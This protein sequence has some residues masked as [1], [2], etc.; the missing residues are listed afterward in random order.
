[1][2]INTV[3]TELD[4]LT[5]TAPN[6][7]AVRTTAVLRQIPFEQALVEQ[8]RD[9][10][11]A[12]DEAIERSAQEAAMAIGNAEDVATTADQRHAWFAEAHDHLAEV[13]RLTQLRT[14][15][16]QMVADAENN[17]LD[18]RAVRTVELPEPQ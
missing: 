6:L 14:V 18:G 1:M 15:A 17:R 2:N 10:C 16:A 11:T 8:A 7:A 13:N 3:Y 9:W 12:L 5:I 4:A